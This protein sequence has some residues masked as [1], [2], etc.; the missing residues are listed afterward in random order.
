MN[1]SARAIPIIPSAVEG[2]HRTPILRQAQHERS[3]CAPLT[4]SLSKGERSGGLP[5]NRVR[6]EELM[7]LA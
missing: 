5:L 6:H 2:R 4:L 7:V 1:V 3:S